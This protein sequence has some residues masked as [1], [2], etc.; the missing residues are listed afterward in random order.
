MKSTGGYCLPQFVKKGKSVFFAIDNINF[1]ED[2]CDGQHT[3]HGTVV[4]RN[5][6]ETKDGAVVNEPLAI[7]DKITPVQIDTV[8]RAESFIAPKPANLR[9]TNSTP[10]QAC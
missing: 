8:F 5:L 3:L 10:V 4:V 2:T 6:E 1:V 9:F 7:P